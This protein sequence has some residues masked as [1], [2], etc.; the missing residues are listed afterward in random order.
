MTTV[1]P[2]Q[3]EINSVIALYSNGQMQEA[4]DAVDTLT[5]DYP[6]EPLLYN[7]SGVC[8]KAIGQLDAA[9]KSF[10]KALAIKPDYTEVNYNLGL[11]FQELD[12]LE[13]AVKSYEKALAFNPDYAEAHNNL[14]VTLKELVQLDAAVKSYEKAVA[15]KPDFAEAHN[16]LGNAFKELGQLD[17]AVK[18]YKKVISLTPDNAE[19]YSNLG[20]TL[21]KLGQLDDAVKSYKK[22][23]SLTPDNAEAYSNLG[24]VFQELGQLDAAVKSFEKALALKPDFAD[25]H[26]NLGNALKELNQLDAAIECYEEAIAIKPD[27][28]E[29]YYNLGNALRALGQPDAAVKRFEHALAIKADYPR[30]LNNL[31]IV[32]MEL[33]QKDDAFKCYEKAITIKPDYVE[34]HLHLGTTK[35]Y[36]AND[37]QIAQMQSILSISD[38][39]QSDRKHLCYALAKVNEDLGKQDE[40]FKFL[41]EGNRLRKQ[42]LNYSLDMDQ[43]THS[44]VKKLFSPSP[45]IVEKSLSYKTST[46][47][48]VFI[49]GMPRSGTSLVEQI[50][51]SHHA[52][53]GAGELGTLNELIF[54]IVKDPST[55]GT[56]GLSEETF[57]SIRQRYLDSLSRFNVPENVITDKMPLN[58]RWIG[59]ILTAFSEAKIVHLKRDARATCWSNYKHHFDSKGN[60]WAYN[61]H[62]LVGFYE[63]YIDLMAF[64]HQLFPNKIYDICYEDLTTNQE[65]ETRK[66]LEYCELDWDEN[67]LN[68]HTNNRVVATASASQ[69]RQ[70]MY[71]GSSEAWK[72]H[73]AYLQPL[74]KALSSY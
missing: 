1:S 21:Q 2:P 61:I 38:L 55:H 17:D 52:V 13:D 57:L 34:A 58:F 12:Q 68:F 46:I 16:N 60:G 33:G 51:S 47:R 35:K 56:N 41:H 29:V 11:T 62:D 10:K 74:I 39:S 18:S 23:I 45:S 20:L 7:I 36:I 44:I 30:A 28:A 63:L 54:P 14:G 3:T 64:W 31:G 67:C 73:E 15:L 26:N 49:L 71:Q 6:N 19:A 59:F 72:K 25:A 27:F 43:I 66:L 24:I 22:A 70:K 42:E 5:K 32:F 40:L 69:V 37:P 50:I 8:Y 48:P 9:V 4:L 53:C 65:E